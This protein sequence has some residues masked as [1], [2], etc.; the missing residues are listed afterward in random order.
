MESNKKYLL[1][2]GVFVLFILR[3]FGVSKLIKGD[4]NSSI[5][6]DDVA[7]GSTSGTK[8][9]EPKQ[10][11]AQP[12][13]AQVKIIVDKIKQNGDSYT[14]QV[15]AENLPEEV[16]PIYTIDQ[17]GRK[18][19]NGQFTKIPG[20]SGTYLVKMVDGSTGRELA[21]LEVAGFEVITQSD[22]PVAST[23]SAGEFQSLL[24]N[25]SDNSLLGGKNPKVART[26]YIRTQGMNDGEKAPGDILSV[27]EK[28]ANGIWA[29]A[30]VVNVGYDQSGRINSVTIRPVYNNESIYNNE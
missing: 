9:E 16:Q 24:L 3:G 28:I 17:I 14:L 29:S 19:P 26:V 15:H 20:Y 5:S 1:Y 12:E 6:T 22:S 27:R 25:Q 11:V 30:N 4:G 10:P 13:T 23:M 2:I 18:S 7:S 21:S 8:N